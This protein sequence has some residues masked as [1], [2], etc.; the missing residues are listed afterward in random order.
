[1]DTKTFKV[2]NHS[3]LTKKIEELTRDG[4]NIIQIIDTSTKSTNPDAHGV[5]YGGPEIQ[6]I[7][8]RKYEKPNV[9]CSSNI[10]RSAPCNP[11]APGGR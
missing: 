7:T 10:I 11:P 1:M 8:Q 6:I 3:Q 4:Y 5:S 2:Q 9:I